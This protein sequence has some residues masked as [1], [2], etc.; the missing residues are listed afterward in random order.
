MTTK[1]AKDVLLSLKSI[2]TGPGAIIP[3]SDDDIMKAVDIAVS[4][5][6]QAEEGG[7]VRS[8]PL[9]KYKHGVEI[10]FP[11]KLRTR[12]NGFNGIIFKEEE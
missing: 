1:E 11:G 6:D 8:D 2:L 9:S 3:Y 7:S 12:S 4:A 10:D 5:I